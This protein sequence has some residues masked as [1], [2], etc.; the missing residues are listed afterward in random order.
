M[1]EI[2]MDNL[3]LNGQEQNNFK[4][5]AGSAHCGSGQ[6]G[7]SPSEY[8]GY[9]NGNTALSYKSSQFIHIFIFFYNS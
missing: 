1:A 5:W 8:P 9:L 2:M 3:K 4:A 7:L 6:S